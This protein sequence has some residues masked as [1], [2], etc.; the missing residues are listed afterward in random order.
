MSF[1]LIGWSRKI[2]M[3]T[4]YTSERV[5]VMIFLE[6]ALSLL[7]YYIETMLFPELLAEE[8]W[9]MSEVSAAEINFEAKVRITLAPVFSWKNLVSV[10]NF[11]F[12]FLTFPVSFL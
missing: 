11:I 7:N 9:D 6:E 5:N 12:A 3:E 4:K 2:Y 10:F 1:T 8:S